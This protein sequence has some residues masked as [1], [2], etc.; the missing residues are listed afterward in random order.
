[1]LK[2]SA[3]VFEKKLAVALGGVFEDVDLRYTLDGTDPD[4][5]SPH[6]KGDVVLDKSAVF[7][8]AAFKGA[9]RSPVI[10]AA[11]SQEKYHSAV[12]ED[13][14]P[15]LNYTYYTSQEIRRLP[16]DAYQRN[17]VGQGQVR[18]ILPQ[19]IAHRQ[20]FFGIQFQGFIEVKERG[21]YTFSGHAD[22]KL[23]VYVHDKRLI[24]ED[25]EEINLEGQILLEAGLHPLRV[26][27]FNERDHAFLELSISGPGLPKQSISPFMLKRK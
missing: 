20:A 27:Y 25:R 19:E 15:G 16:F 4:H 12:K 24:N 3:R 21:L 23:Q 5:N 10:S 18:Q 13:V 17:V 11:F 1:M 26:E 9:H 7:K 8:A 14:K 2:T 6:Y 22:D